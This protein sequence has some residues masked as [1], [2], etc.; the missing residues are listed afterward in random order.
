MSTVTPPRLSR[1]FAETAAG[2]IHYRYHRP[3]AP[4]GVLL[5]LH[6]SPTS[7]WS[8]RTLGGAIAGEYHVICPDT[9]GN[10]DSDPLDMEQPRIEDF[11]TAMLG[12]LDALEI[13]RASAYGSHTGA[14]T[15]IEL[16][17]AAPD[18]IAKVVLDGIALF[19]GAER[20]DMLRNYAPEIHPDLEGRHLTWAFQFMRDQNIFFPW[21]KRD[22]E[23]LRGMGL[24]PPE[25][26]HAATL[27]VL[28]ALTTYHKA[29]RAAFSHR[30]RERMP[31][32]TQEALALCDAQDPL[33]DQTREAVSLAPRGQF[34]S[35]PS[36]ADADFL[37]RKRD[38][39]LS[40]LTL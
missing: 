35:M 23:H 8:M 13:D 17:I 27:E 9:P 11:A 36:Y 28:K 32:L 30:V 4:R 33:H 38:A 22:A 26:L 31:L 25:L 29:Y 3:K 21:F 34:M 16:G 1:A 37:V 6:A 7:S 19:E 2:R 5:M 15:A 18:R 20:E 14:H 10:G 24:V 40:F 39:I 12:L